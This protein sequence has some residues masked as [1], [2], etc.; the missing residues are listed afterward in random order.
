MRPAGDLAEVDLTA[1]E[2][3]ASEADA[4]AGELGAFEADVAAGELC[5][6]E[7]EHG[8]DPPPGA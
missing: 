6:V 7:L 1:G 4:L 2:L 5:L 3:G 8:L